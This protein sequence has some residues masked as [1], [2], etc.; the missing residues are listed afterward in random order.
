MQLVML[1]T[2]GNQHYIFSSPRLR[3]NIGASS[4]LTHLEQ[5]TEEALAST[6]AAGAWRASR[7]LPAGP[8]ADKSQWVSRSSGKVIVMVDEPQRARDLIGE[9]TRRAL[10]QAP[11]LD[12]SGV[13]IEIPGARGADGVHAQRRLPR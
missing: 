2:N 4:L 5:W 10:A 6:G 7:G 3:D 12:V 1:E 9:V 8:G 13:F 11:G